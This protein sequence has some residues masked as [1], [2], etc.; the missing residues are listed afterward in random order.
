MKKKPD[1]HNKKQ[2]ELIYDLSKTVL[3]MSFPSFIFMAIATQL[4]LI[5][6]GS[7][8]LLFPDWKTYLLWNSL[9]IL[10]ILVF[11]FSLMFT[12]ISWLYLWDLEKREKIK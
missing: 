12:M 6:S 4:F 2:T 10:L 8:A 5:E 3:F 7:G 9:G 1:Y 11:I